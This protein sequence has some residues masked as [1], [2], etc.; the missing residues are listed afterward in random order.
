[1]VFPFPN[2]TVLFNPKHNTK[3]LFKIKP[4]RTLEYVLF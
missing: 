4:Y 2:L 3:L 1:M